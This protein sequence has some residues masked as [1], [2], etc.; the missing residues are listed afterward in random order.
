MARKHCR[1][2]ATSHRYLE[3]F[4]SLPEHPVAAVVAI[5]VWVTHWARLYKKLRESPLL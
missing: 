3:A 2:V 4:L 5:S 1:L